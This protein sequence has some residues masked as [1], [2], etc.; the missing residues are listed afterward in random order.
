MEPCFLVPID[1]TSQCTRLTARCACTGRKQL[2]RA[3]ACGARGFLIIE[4]SSASASATFWAGCMPLLQPHC[5]LRTDFRHCGG[6]GCSH[7]TWAHRRTCEQRWFLDS[8]LAV[9]PRGVCNQD[10]PPLVSVC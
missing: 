2:G 5:S 4:G 6:S 3:V 1:S 10:S 8:T 7:R 9:K